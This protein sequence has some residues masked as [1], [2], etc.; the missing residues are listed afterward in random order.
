MARAKQATA[1]VALGIALCLAGCAVGPDYRRPAVDLPGAWRVE[2]PE[3]RA[4]AGTVW[5]AQYGDPVLDDLIAAGLRENADLRIAAARVEES[6]GRL[7]VAR[8]GLFPEIGMGAS[9]E[10]ERIS[11]TG[12]PP[13]SATSPNLGSLFH[14][15]LFASWEI[16]LWGKARRATE[17]ARAE[18]LASEEGR[19]GTVLSIVDTVAT[20][21]I[22]LRTL[23]R[24]LEIVRRTARTREASLRLFELRFK[25]G[26]VSDLERDQAQAEYE[27]AMAAIPAIEK[28]IA[29]QENALSALLGRNPGPIPRGLTIDNLAFP[30]VPAGLPSSLLARRPDLRQAEQALVAANARIGVARAQYF[31]S[32]ALTGALGATSP[33]LSSL[34]EGPARAWDLAVPLA[35]PIFSGGVLSGQVKI[36]E[37]QRDQMLLA[38][39]QAIRNA[40]RDVEDA[41]AD[42]QR[43]QEQLAAQE[44]QV[45]TLQRTAQVARL[46]YDNGY[47]S[48]LEVLDAERGLYDAEL[49]ATETRG[50]LHAALA[51]LYM[52]MGGGW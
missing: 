23:D 35:A 18:L 27:R 32:I 11:R 19:R 12:L 52:A 5:W 8:G 20:G 28:A 31:P 33:Q 13:L 22:N 42:R 45:E 47:T 37:A 48:H 4:I 40:F 15:T 1:R 25:G 49:A 24:R 30:A 3:A 29:F 36:A 46:R 26:L 9:A 7:A 6:A 14:A 17:A 39:R 34:F 50:A 41:L 10:R 2:A 21:Y 44:R 38:Y 51:T 43:T 16:D